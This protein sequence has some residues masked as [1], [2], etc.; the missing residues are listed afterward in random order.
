MC[1][2]TQVHVGL[3]SYVRMCACVYV[4]TCACLFVVLQSFFSVLLGSFA[5]ASSVPSVQI[6][7]EARAAAASV[8]SIIDRVCNMTRLL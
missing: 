6:S 5:L 2:C 8:Y 4:F 3:T 7:S 1:E